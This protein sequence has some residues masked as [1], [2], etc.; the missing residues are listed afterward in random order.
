MSG[1]FL[2][3]LSMS[4]TASYVAIAVIIVRFFLKKSPKI[5]SYVIWS[6]VLFRLLCPITFESQLSLI[7]L[8]ME[9][10][11]QNIVFTENSSIDTGVSVIGDTLN[12]TVNTSL[13]AVNSAAIIN[14]IDVIIQIGSIIWVAGIILLLIYGLASY[15]K[16]KNKLT[17]ATLIDDNIFETDQIRTPFVMG[18]IKPKIFIP[19]NIPDEEFN[20]ILKHEQTHIK[21]YDYIIKL[22]SFLALTIHWFNPLMW[23]SYFLMSKD[24]EMSCDETVIKSTGEDIRTKYSNSLLSLSVKQSGLLVPL[25]FGE[26]NVKSR[27]KNILNYKKTSFWI[28][29]TVIAIVAGIVVALGTNPINEQ[30]FQYQFPLKAEDIESVLAEKEINMYIKEYNGDDSRSITNLSNDKNMVFGI[31]S[32]LRDNYKVLSMTW[33]LPEKLTSEE[34]YDFFQN[35]LSKQFELAGV[36]YG[37]KRGLDKE[38]NKMLKYYLDEKNYNNLLVWKERVGNDHL[39]AQIK[40][41]NGKR[42]NIVNL[43]IIPDELYDDYLKTLNN[44]KEFVAAE[45][46]KAFLTDLYTVDS[47]EVDNYKYLLNL[48]TTDEKALSDAMQINDEVLK[49]LMT[50]EA[51]DILVKNRENLW[52][53]KACHEGNYTMQV[54]EIQF[55]ENKNNI[56]KDEAGYNFQVLSKVISHDGTEVTNSVEGLIELRIID[57]NWKVTG[58][59]K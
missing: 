52:F 36:F 59:S 29:A 8:N 30:Q 41:I 20:Y 17:I 35:E 3:I 10:I 13:P 1:V 33:Y 32:Q 54:S 56:E 51:Y 44:S 40:S 25:A 7:P 6:V 48:N 34:V 47:K 27:I 22:L 18:I 50:D 31:N 49:S 4:L 45:I 39:K 43:L 12:N 38:L 9:S 15:I 26:S 14:P 11:P 28:F 53:A 2:K 42:N 24:M 37:N 46:A 23:L 16:L 57:G 58:Y 5:F 19:V 55:S 21:R